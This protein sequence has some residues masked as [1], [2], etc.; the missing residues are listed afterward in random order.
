[1]SCK[2]A[3]WTIPFTF[4]IA[5]LGCVA[6]CWTGQHPL[7]R[8]KDAA[9]F[10]GILLLLVNFIQSARRDHATG[11]FQFLTESLKE[12]FKIRH[13]LMGICRRFDPNSKISQQIQICDRL[14]TAY[15][16]AAKR[17]KNSSKVPLPIPGPV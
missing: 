16:T 4:L 11:D 15:Q 6:L 17:L 14:I 13:T 7:D 1:M 3:N 9:T 2:R 5:V 10:G 8:V 12:L